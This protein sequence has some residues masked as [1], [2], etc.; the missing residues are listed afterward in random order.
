[1]REYEAWS[2][3]DV[4]SVHNDYQRHLVYLWGFKEF[5]E[6]KMEAWG[7][8]AQDHTDGHV[9]ECLAGFG[10]GTFDTPTGRYMGD[11]SSIFVV[12]LF[13]LYRHTAN[14]TFL[15]SLWPGAVKA[16][17]WCITNADGTN[18][19][20]PNYGLPQYVTTTYDHFGFEKHRTVA[21]NAHIYLTALTAAK[22]LAAA[23]GD[24]AT[25][26][27][28]EDALVRSTVGVVDDRL[29]NSTSRFFR[30]H[31]CPP[32]SGETCPNGANQ[33]FTDTLYGQMLAHHHFG[34]FTLPKSYLES[35]LAHEWAQNQDT[36]GMRVLSSPVQEDSIWMNGP[37]TWS[38]L[39]LALGT[40]PFN[41]ALEPFK[42]MSENFRMRLRD[43]WNL[44]A[45]THT[46]GSIKPAETTRPIEQ[47]APREQGH[48][49]F[50]MTDLYLLPLLSGQTVDLPAGKLT[51]VPRFPPPYTLPVLI[52]GVEGTL[53]RAVAGGAYTLEV[54]FGSLSLPK[55]GLIADDTACMQA[56]SLS[57]G[58]SIS[59]GGV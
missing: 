9:Y 59:W 13:E 58:E 46:D 8:W 30:C 21:Y 27:M 16:I 37:P 43:Q 14:T 11:T 19:S 4:D 32:D 39:Q 2:C 29:W 24:T 44:R 7:S 17:Q 22:A 50:M 35:H 49:G 36:Y 48:Y 3:D 33:V 53:T 31:T 42:R 20:E 28:A 47:G 56:V 52:A 38:Y 10:H 15:K 26:A 55:G 57:A 6:Q 12:E 34:N 54:A 5:E 1:M 25:L 18:A 40:M 41:Q 23:V 45:L 51:F